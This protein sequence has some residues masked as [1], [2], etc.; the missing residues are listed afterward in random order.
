MA[1]GKARCGKTQSH[2]RQVFSKVWTFSFVPL[3][4]CDLTCQGQCVLK[5]IPDTVGTRLLC[6]TCG[7]SRIVS[8][9]WKFD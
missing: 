3:V 9:A 2:K 8:C 1:Q 6:D 4:Q 5:L 7:A